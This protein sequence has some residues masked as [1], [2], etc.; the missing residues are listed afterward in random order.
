MPALTLRG[1]R[2][3]VLSGV[4]PGER[5][6]MEPMEFVW[7]AGRQCLVMGAL[8]MIGFVLRRR[9]LISGEGTQSLVNLLLYGILPCLVMK[10][11]LLERT[12]EKTRTLLIAIAAALCANLLAMLIS[13]IWFG[14][15]RPAE[16]IGAAFSNAGFMGLPLALA[17]VGEEAALYMAPFIAMVS[18][19]QWLYGLP[20]LSG[21]REKMHFKNVI[22][23]PV[24]LSL[25]AGILLYFA[26]FEVPEAARSVLNYMGNM[27]APA[28][29][30][31]LG[32]YLTRVS[33]KELTTDRNAYLC[34]LARLIVI[35]L[36]TMALL[37]LLPES[38]RILKLSTMIA[39]CSPVGTNV[40]VFARRCGADTSGPVKDVCVSTV[41]SLI[42]L[43]L[44][45]GLANYL[46]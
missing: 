39:A 20:V 23:N 10:S 19:L 35:P 43:P 2:I 37:S 34:S 13:G 6:W 27:S 18:T 14:K 5:K 3:P 38:F 41:L 40:V 30:I 26:P 25:I 45:V 17:V 12:P 9:E 7:I 16:N 21:G 42:T 22:L 24:V 8:M 4:S 31:I 44:L 32:T 36:C 29:M 28:A 15:R 11:F 46:W 1:G 33:F